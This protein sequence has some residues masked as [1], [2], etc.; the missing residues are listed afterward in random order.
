MEATIAALVMMVLEEGNEYD[1][2]THHR[3][4]QLRRALYSWRGF[5][6]AVLFVEEEKRRGEEKVIGCGKSH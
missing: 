4:R 2:D 5:E 6:S 1:L 3:N